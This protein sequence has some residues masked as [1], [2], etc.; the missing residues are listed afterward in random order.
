[1]ILVAVLTIAVTRVAAQTVDT[2]NPCVGCH[3]DQLTALAA[4]GGH[5][6]LVS[7][8]GCHKDRRPNRVGRG[9]R[10]KPNC[11]DCHD[12][13]NGHPPRKTELQ[14]ARATRNCL[15][16]HDVHGSTNLHL[17]RTDV[18]RQALVLSITFTSEEGAAAGGFTDPAHPGKG[19]CEVCHRKTDF[20]VRSGTGKPHFTDSCT[21][22][23][24]HPDHF[25]P[26]ATEANCSICHSDEATRFTKPSGHSA[27]FTCGGCHAEVSPTPG[28]GH[29]AVEA[30]Q[31]CHP[32]N[33]THAPN[34][35]PGLPCTQC[36]DPHGTGN[37]NLVLDMLTTTLGTQVPIHFDNLNGLADGSFASASAPGTGVCEV[38][39]TTT[40]HYR[41][42]G[43]GSPH[44][45]FS[46]LP[47]H[48]HT[49]GFE[50]Q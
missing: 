9:H 11:S 33:A 40:G 32:D 24:L 15:G 16:C 21:L 45:T 12:Q 41:A 27:N 26:V 28:T 7:C 5:S 50:P 30:C 18:V 37:L 4:T 6:P 2:S 43:T 3:T 13:P 25:E 19:L 49:S 14:G 47:C 38:C 44:Y 29:R 31:T 20:Y 48:L 39:H 34:G 42:D 8:E 1:M 36:H 23:H 10:T 17:V 35:P 46:C 22:C